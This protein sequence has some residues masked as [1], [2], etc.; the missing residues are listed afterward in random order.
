M[1]LQ[2]YGLAEITEEGINKAELMRVKPQFSLIKNLHHFFIAPSVCG[3]HA[4]GAAN[5]A[6]KR[7]W[8]PETY[9]KATS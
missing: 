7:P 9:R 5:G 4:L 8:W 6:A 1:S 2:T 3:F